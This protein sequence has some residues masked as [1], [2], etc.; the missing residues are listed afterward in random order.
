MDWK[1]FYEKGIII[2]MWNFDTCWWWPFGGI[3]M[4]F[5]WVG[6]IILLFWVV[7]KF[8]KGSNTESKGNALDIARE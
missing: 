3:S 4:I 1:I 6:L 5:L 7:I 8:T 2:M